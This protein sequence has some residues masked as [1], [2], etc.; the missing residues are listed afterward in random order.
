MKTY[1]IALDAMGGDFG[2]QVT[3]PAS[4]QA[5][6]YFPSLEIYLIGQAERIHQELELSGMV[7]PPRLHIID[8]PNVIDNDARPSYALRSSQGSSMRV[9]LEALASGDVQ[10]C[11]SAGN[12]GA[13]MGLSRHLLKLLP[14]I[15]RPALITAIPTTQQNQTWLLDLGANAS[16]D[17]DTLFSFAIMGA[18]MAEL[19]LGYQPRVAL[20]NIGTEENKGN[21]LV[22]SC[23]QLLKQCQSINY[24]GFI[25]GD[26]L[27]SGHADVI[28]C[29]GFVGN[30]CL[31]SSEGAAKLIL[32]KIKGQ[33]ENRPIRKWFFETFFSRFFKQLNQL[34]PDHYNGA[35]LLIARHCSKKSWKRRCCCFFM[36]HKGSG[37]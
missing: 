12:T 3:V 26:Q 35:S 23:A 15:D 36:R 8:A 29:D 6:S 1:S 4:V 11:V 32:N 20:L 5:L 14:Y 28:V 22:K 25:E 34:N 18:V 19:R 13:L 24:I 7:V 9:A 17:T 2:P 33:I 21:D 30:V 31:K 16:V 27:Y 37:S 10:A